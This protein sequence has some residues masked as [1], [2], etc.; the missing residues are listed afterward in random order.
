[1]PAPDTARCLR[2]GCNLLPESKANSRRREGASENQGSQERKGQDT[3]L[4]RTL[5]PSTGP[6]CLGL[7]HSCRAASQ[8]GKPT[9]GGILAKLRYAQLGTAKASAWQPC[10]PPWTGGKCPKLHVLAARP[11][12][13][14]QSPHLGAPSGSRRGPGA[15][16]GAPS[17]R[18]TWLDRERA[19]T[20]VNAQDGLDDLQV[21]GLWCSVLR[22][23]TGSGRSEDPAPAGKGSAPASH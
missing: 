4:P 9:A 2:P 23:Q 18:Y 16:P 12:H 22:S 19:G 20:S 13:P 17:R 15:E 8:P 10:V 5:L 14:A 6:S 7:S 11:L 1:M 3:P 21:Q